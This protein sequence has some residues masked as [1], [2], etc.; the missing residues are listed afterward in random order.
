M[1]NQNLRDAASSLEFSQ[2]LQNTLGEKIQKTMMLLYESLVLTAIE[3]PGL[4]E[5]LV[6]DLKHIKGIK[7]VNCKRCGNISEKKN[8]TLFHA[9]DGDHSLKRHIRFLEGSS[10]GP[11]KKH[12]TYGGE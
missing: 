8:T 7:K 9:C 6:A 4:Q 2:D 12:H 10:R 11:S 5:H 1:A 3:Y